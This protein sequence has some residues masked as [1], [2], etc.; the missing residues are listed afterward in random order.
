MGQLYMLATR[1]T[2]CQRPVLLSPQDFMNGVATNTIHLQHK[3]LRYYGGA[4]PCTCE[5]P[6]AVH[7]CMS[8]L[9]LHAAMGYLA[10]IA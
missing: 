5:F 1:P 8:C 10:T 9:L 6:H 7:E 3:K 2:A 4:P